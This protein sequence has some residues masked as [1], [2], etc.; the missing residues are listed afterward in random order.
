[1]INAKDALYVYWT[2]RMTEDWRVGESNAFVRLLV[3]Q[4]IS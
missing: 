1:M 2:D 4:V 3:I